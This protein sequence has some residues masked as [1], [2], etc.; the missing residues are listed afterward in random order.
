MNANTTTTEYSLLDLCKFYVEGVAVTVVGSTGVIIN[1]TA[2]IFLLQT[3]RRHVFQN[4]LLSLTIYDLALIILMLVSFAFPQFSGNYRSHVLIHAL[5][6]LIPLAQTVLACSSCTTVALSVERYVSI[7]TPYRRGP[8]ASRSANYIL[9]V[10]AFSILYN[11]PRYF[12]WV[13]VQMPSL[14]EPQCQQGRG[15]VAT[16]EFT[17]PVYG[18]WLQEP[19]G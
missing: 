2:L 7:C 19:L 5:P 4:L 8:K 12:E 13:T 11:L 10:L 18:P 14:H 16:D 6:F 15:D 17:K 9:P 1:L 3:R